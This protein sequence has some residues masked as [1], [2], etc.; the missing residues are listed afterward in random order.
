[1]PPPSQSVVNVE[2]NIYS[3]FMI[4]YK[5]NNYINCSGIRY[6]FLELFS[7]FDVDARAHLKQALY[8][9]TNEFINI[10]FREIDAFRSGII[11]FWA[12]LTR[13]VH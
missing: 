3:L 12:F 4:S 9:S 11:T 13:H 6:L 8:F 5:S 10:Q 2:R 1:M 7:M